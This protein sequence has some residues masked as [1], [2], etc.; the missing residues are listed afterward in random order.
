M[1]RVSALYVLL[2]S[3]FMFLVAMSI[4]FPWF[5]P[6]TVDG[7][8]SIC[9]VVASIPFRIWWISLFEGPRSGCIRLTLILFISGW[10]SWIEWRPKELPWSRVIESWPIGLLPSIPPCPWRNLKTAEMR[11]RPFLP[12]TYIDYAYE[13]V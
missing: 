2:R 1:I 8:R 7:K 3:L 6:E 12:A 10:E 5:G 13:S 4:T 9:S 11:G